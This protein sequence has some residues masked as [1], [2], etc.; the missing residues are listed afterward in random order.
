MFQKIRSGLLMLWVLLV[1][2]SMVFAQDTST[3]FK[4]VVQVMS[5]D[6][7]YGLY[8]VLRWRGSA[9]IISSDGL[10]MTN[11]H[12][13]TKENGNPL[14]AFAVCVSYSISTRPVCSYT[15][16]LITQDSDRDI[17]L[18]RIDSTDINGNKVDYSLFTPL[19]IDDNYIP[20][21]QDKTVAIWYPSVW[22][23]TIT[24]T[25][26][27]VAGSQTY[28]GYSYIK[29]DTAIAPG[30][31][32]WPLLHDGKII[33]INT[34]SFW[35]N[36]WYALLVSEVIDFI[37]KYS[38]SD[39]VKSIIPTTTFQSYLASS[40]TI[41]T[42]KQLS[43]KVFSFSFP[44]SYVITNYIANKM[45][46]GQ[47]Q[48]PDDTNIQSF[49]LQLKQVSKISSDDDVVYLLK[50]NYWYNPRYH[51]LTKETIS[52]ITMYSFNYTSDLSAWD[53]QSAKI[54]IGKYNTNSIVELIIELPSLSDATKQDTIKRNITQFISWISIKTGYMSSIWS[55]LVMDYPKLTLKVMKNMFVNIVDLADNAYEWYTNPFAVFQLSTSYENVT[56]TLV[57]NTVELGKTNSLQD[58]FS[59]MTEWINSTNKS[60][61]SYHGHKWFVF[62]TEQPTDTIS[63]ESSLINK[64]W[65]YVDMGLC[66]MVIY[67]WDDEDVILYA[68]LNVEKTKLQLYQKRFLNIVASTL[69]LPDIWDGITNLPKQII[70]SPTV[71]FKN[72]ADQSSDFNSY[73]NL[74]V[75]YGI[76]PQWDTINLASP[77]T[78]KSYLVLY[79]KAL[80]NISEDKTDLVLKSTGINPEAY[81]DKDMFP[82]FST[83]VRLRMSGV[84]LSDY[85]QKTL[86]TFE[87]LSQ[88]TYQNQR[89][90]IQDWEYTIFKW[91]QF[92]IDDVLPNT[93]ISYIPYM[94]Y[95]YDQIAGLQSYINYNEKWS[96]STPEFG[97]VHTKNNQDMIVSCAN[98][99]MMDKSCVSFY[100][101][102]ANQI[103]SSSL[104]QYQVVT[105]GEALEYLQY[106]I[107]ISLFDSQWKDKKNI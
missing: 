59:I 107:D 10:I 32:W 55:S 97:F 84:S 39:S 63:Y 76:I 85:S 49:S 92:R 9:S 57:E 2:C 60:L 27:V 70:Q 23:E 14:T 64:Q 68:D 48:S 88:T 72:T 7:I 96:L 45:L 90:K 103:Y 33:G 12:V 25:V 62:C 86:K 30:S 91:I 5:Y 44:K 93:D 20:S 75:R 54:Y 52:G 94:S 81:M 17:A 102:L 22:A 73:L 104:W 83:L 87:L 100:K 31:S 13:V 37:K 78:Y 41:Q 79:L 106:F 101:K 8:P 80:Y 65:K 46:V 74:L 47:L 71:N 38:R 29:T 51:T 26:G 1:S 82:L 53:S 50:K 95:F 58:R 40:Q 11:S 21:A 6:S 42:Q 28:N 43:D 105:Y 4:W 19:M 15:A 99:P 35:W 77:M 56:Y 3:S 34:F 24:Q 16:S 36:L 18:L 69:Q 98:K 66:R 67:L 61:I 89:K